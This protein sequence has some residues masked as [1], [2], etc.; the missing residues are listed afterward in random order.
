MDPLHI[1]EFASKRYFEKIE[2]QQQSQHQQQQQQHGTAVETSSSKFIL[3]I[4]GAEQPW[5]DPTTKHAEHH[6]Q[7][8]KEKEKRGLFGRLRSSKSISS[9]EPPEHP[10]RRPSFA[11]VASAISIGEGHTAHRGT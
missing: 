11:S 2:Q 7:P 1:T 10:L 5:H 9:S 8:Q 4:R 6:A 3:P